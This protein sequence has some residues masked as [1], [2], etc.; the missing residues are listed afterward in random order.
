MSAIK[1][2][3]NLRERRTSSSAVVLIADRLKKTHY[4]AWFLFLTLFVVI[5]GSRP[6]N[7]NVS[8]G[9]VIRAKCG[10]EPGAHK[11]LENYQLLSL[12][13]DPESHNAKRYRDRWTEYMM[14]SI[15]DQTV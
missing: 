13:T 5:A 15:V 1:S 10:T 11:L 3:Q 12:Y 7:K 8:T 2:V 14:M 6:A 9:A 4:C